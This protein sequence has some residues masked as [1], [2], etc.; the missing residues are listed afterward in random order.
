M[1]Q[2]IGPRSR[3]L[4]WWRLLPP[5]HNFSYG[6]I[7]RSGGIL[8]TSTSP[9]RHLGLLADMAIAWLVVAC[10]GRRFPMP[11]PPGR[12]LKCKE[13]E[14]NWGRA[15]LVSA[16]DMMASQVRR[17]ERRHRRMAHALKGS[18]TTMEGRDP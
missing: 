13:K 1:L 4:G 18:R 8:S 12:G 16:N 17:S 10:I 3:M 7:T 9:G 6:P 11:Q 5:S 15:N 2:A 14:K